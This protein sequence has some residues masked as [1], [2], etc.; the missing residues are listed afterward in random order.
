MVSLA[1]SLYEIHM[2]T[3]L[4]MFFD[5][6]GG[7]FVVWSFLDGFAWYNYGYIFAFCV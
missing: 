3:V 2:F 7:I 1:S 4:P 6:F 5:V